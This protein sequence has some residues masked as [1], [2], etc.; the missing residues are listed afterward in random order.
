[1]HASTEWSDFWR[2]DADSF[3]NSIA[4]LN[5]LIRFTAN[6]DADT[7]GRVPF[8]YRDPQHGGARR[9]RIVLFHH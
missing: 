3:G 8:R 5:Y 2:I 4:R 6:P 7:R 9:V 1:M